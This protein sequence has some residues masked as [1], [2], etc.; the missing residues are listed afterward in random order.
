MTGISGYVLDASIL[1][2]R[3]RPSETAHALVR[4]LLFALVSRKSELYIPAIAL[5]ETAAALSRGGIPTYTA[6]ATLA[7]LRQLPGMMIVGVD[8]TLGDIA[9]RIAALQCMRGCDA[10]Y[11]ALALTFG[12]SL[13]TLDRQQRQRVPD[14][15]MA[16]APDELLASL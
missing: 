1:V 8:I 6:L 15:V 13:V 7:E 9:A 3:V 16:Q 12:A 11:V 10:V 5:A 4:D 2:S 14:M